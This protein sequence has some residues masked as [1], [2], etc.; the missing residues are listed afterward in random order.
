MIGKWKEGYDLVLAIRRH[1][2]GETRFKLW[3]AALL[4]RLIRLLGATHVRADSGD[5]RLMSRRV[6]EAFRK[7]RE[8]H[9]FIRGMVGWVGFRTAEVY[10]HR[11]AQGRRNEI[12]VS[13]NVALC[14]GR[15]RLLLH[16][17]AAN[18][19]RGGG[20]PGRH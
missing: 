1:R 3:T 17:S 9:R 8:H 15:H 16:R 18:I 19:L 4:Y 12:S 11:K 7:M 5:F 6:L 14:G 13:E 10:Y 20:G 2:D